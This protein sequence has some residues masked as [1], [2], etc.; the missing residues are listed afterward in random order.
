MTA[1]YA[2][3]GG[4]ILWTDAAG[5]VWTVPSLE[6]PTQIG[7]QVRD[8]VA[9]GNTIAPYTPPLATAETIE[10]AKAQVAQIAD[11]FAASVT[12]P[13][14]ETERASWPTKETAARAHL[15]GNAAAYQTAMLQA[16]ANVTG[17]TLTAL[18]T[19]IVGNADLYTALA[20]SIVGWR[21]AT[22]AA[23]DALVI[24]TA[25]T[26]DVDA[27]VASAKAQGEAMIASALGS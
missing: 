3:P 1:R 26:A 10:A 12:G 4:P 8:W 19:K 5:T 15:A 13:V 27:A 18:A 17:E 25:T 11:T 23:L 24:G 6:N 16:E 2:S 14:A 7:Q 9:A 21:R 22:N 20:G